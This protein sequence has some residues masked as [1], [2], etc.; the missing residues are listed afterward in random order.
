MNARKKAIKPLIGGFMVN[1]NI[2]RSL[3]GL[4]RLKSN[5]ATPNPTRKE[6]YI[7]VWGYT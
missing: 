6:E 2:L 4:V 5:Q 1:L 3:E 7:P